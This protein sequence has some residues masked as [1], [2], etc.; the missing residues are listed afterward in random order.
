MRILIFV[1]LA[2]LLLYCAPP[3]VAELLKGGIDC[4]VSITMPDEVPARG[5]ELHVQARFTN[6]RDVVQ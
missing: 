4:D 3:K 1:A 5:E 6:C 2:L